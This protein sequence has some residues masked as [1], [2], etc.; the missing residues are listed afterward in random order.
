MKYF[1]K[2]F[3]ISLLTFVV[4]QVVEANGIFIPWVHS[5][6]DDILCSPIVLGFALFVQQQFTYR[7]AKYLL[8]KG[9]VILFVIWYALIFEVF[10]PISSEQ[11]HADWLDVVAYSLGALAFF[12]FGNRSVPGL[13]FTS[14]KER[15]RQTSIE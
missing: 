14:K 7:N 15:Q 2:I 8:T 13:V 5:Y 9:M 3:W 10:L 11:F 6:L 12:K 1:S 4:N